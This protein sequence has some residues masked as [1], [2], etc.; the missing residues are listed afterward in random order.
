MRFFSYILMPFLFLSYLLADTYLKLNHSSLCHSKGCQLAASL[1]KV[2]SIVL[3]Y[4]GIISAVLLLVLGVLAYKKSISKKIFL[5]YLFSCTLFETIMIGYQFFA[6]PQM[7]KFCL[8]VYGF[9][10]LILFLNSKR[11]FIAAFVPILAIFIALSFLAIPKNKS[12][13]TVD[14]NY[15]IQSPTCPHCKLVKDY[16][17][18]KKIPFIRL[19]A[20]DIE[21][22]SFIRYLGYKTIPLLIVKKGSSITV[23][24]GDEDIVEYFE[25]SQ[26]IKNTAISSP[27]INQPID[28]LSTSSKGD[29][30]EIDL[31]LKPSC[32][33]K[34]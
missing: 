19:N 5:I 27:S 1:L 24:N 29:G 21:N 34:K 16:M 25:K 22:R 2:D 18:Q 4:V 28:I 7:C 9:L 14:G 31:G 32:G 26:N 6:S 15:L 8:G 3:N 11:Y 10:L 23:I 30:C 13:I 17:H 20:S 33:K 12:F